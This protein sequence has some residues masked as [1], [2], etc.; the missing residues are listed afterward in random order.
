MVGE[1]ARQLTGG[2]GPRGPARI[3]QGVRA[4]LV[5]AVLAVGLVVVVVVVVLELV[6][7]FVVVSATRD[8]L[9]VRCRGPRHCALVG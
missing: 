3:P 1:V 9:G 7:V 6:I 2:S 8:V 4:A 5:G